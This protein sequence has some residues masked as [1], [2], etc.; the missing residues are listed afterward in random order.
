MVDKWFLF[1]GTRCREDP[2]FRSSEG[3]QGP[4]VSMLC[5]SLR[6]VFPFEVPD[7]FVEPPS[8][9]CLDEA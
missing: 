2:P 7:V 5:S 3:Q 9:V 8:G 1:L 4:S 6:P